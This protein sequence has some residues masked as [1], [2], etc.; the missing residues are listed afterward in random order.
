MN[1]TCTFCVDI[2]KEA[3]KA[4]KKV[5]RDGPFLYVD[6]KQVAFRMYKP[7]GCEC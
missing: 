2:V 7:K 6:G 3:E 4:G 5:T 1:P